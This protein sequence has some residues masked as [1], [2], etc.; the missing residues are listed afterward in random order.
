MNDITWS[1]CRLRGSLEAVEWK[2]VTASRPQ[3]LED[4]ETGQQDDRAR[5]LALGLT[6]RVGCMSNIVPILYILD[7][8]SDE[9]L[10]SFGSRV[11]GDEVDGLFA[12]GH[13]E[14]RR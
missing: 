7:Q 4:G 1:L 3:S 8:D 12:G 11:H 14:I 10:S 2:E 9:T 13:G 5:R 6:F